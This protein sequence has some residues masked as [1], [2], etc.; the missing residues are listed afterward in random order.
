MLM[1]RALAFFRGQNSIPCPHFPNSHGIIFFADPHLLNPVPSYRY[2][3]HGGWGVAPNIGTRKLPI[4][5]PRTIPLTPLGA[6]LTSRPISVHSKGF[7][8]KLNPLDATLTK[9][10]G[11]LRPAKSVSS[12]GITPRRRMS[13]WRARPWGRLATWRWFFAMAGQVASGTVRKTSTT[14]GSKCWPD[15]L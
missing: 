2:K 9:N 11:C 1:R 14:R 12:Y 4:L 6:T 8:E 3:N 7:T 10:R 13:A 5:A 15:K